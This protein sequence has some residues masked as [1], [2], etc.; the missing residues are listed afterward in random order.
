MDKKRIKFL[1]D[2]N[3]GKIKGAQRIIAKKLGISDTS[4]SLWFK[5]DK[6]PSLDSIIKMAKVF[7]KSEAEIMD[8]FSVEETKIS[9]DNNSFADVR[10]IELIKEKMKRFETEIDYLKEKIK[11]LELKSK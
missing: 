6:K 8:I 1:Q 10:D 11:N 5:N 2:I 9:A 3:N 4:V 7:K